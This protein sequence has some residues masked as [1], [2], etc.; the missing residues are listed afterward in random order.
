M[1]RGPINVLYLVDESSCGGAHEYVWTLVARLNR[2]VFRPMIAAPAALI[3]MMDP[4]LPSDV[5]TFPLVARNVPRPAATWHLW[6]VLRS[7][8]IGILHSHLSQG[9]GLAMALGWMARVPVRV[10]TTDA[11][12][13]RGFGWEMAS[14]FSDLIAVH[15]TTDFIAISAA[16]GRHLEVERGIP[17]SKISVIRNGVGLDR[18]DANRMGPAELRTSI[19]IAQDAPLVLVLGRLEA[20]T[21]HRVLLQAWKAVRASFPA[22]RLVCVGDGSLRKELEATAAETGPDDSVRFVGYQR[23]PSDWLALA[24]FTVLPLVEDGLPSVA[25]ESLAAGR[26]VIANLVDGITEAVLD[27]RTGLTVP[28]GSPASLAA[29]ICQLLGSPDLARRMGGEGRKLVEGRFSQRRQV[30]ETEALYLRSWRMRTGG[31]PWSEVSAPFAI[32][33][34]RRSRVSR[35]KLG[36]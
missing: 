15:L 9:R 13:R 6:H 20:E 2:S 5:E 8:Q 7:K 22:A 16:N 12:V 36:T 33:T 32:E 11:R 34:A 19:G 26:A 18:F 27:G 3:E 21:G 1:K 31:N 28:P 29:G 23:N 14:Y 25:I 4:E 10:E 24:D 35:S 17:A 30:G